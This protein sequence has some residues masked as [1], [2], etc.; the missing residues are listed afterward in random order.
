MKI[1]EEKELILKIWNDAMT[2]IH[3]ILM[4]MCYKH[5]LIYGTTAKLIEIYLLR[6]KKFIR[7][8]TLFKTLITS[9]RNSTETENLW[10]ERIANDGQKYR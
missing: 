6:Y 2:F 7:V 3:W 4:I 1:K 5:Y 10:E 8:Y 9:V